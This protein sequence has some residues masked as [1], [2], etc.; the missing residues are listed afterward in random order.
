MKEKNTKGE[1]ERNF[2]FLYFIIVFPERLNKRQQ[3]FNKNR[4]IY[5]N[6]KKK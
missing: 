5:Y 6:L 2:F 3:I 4:L 1:D